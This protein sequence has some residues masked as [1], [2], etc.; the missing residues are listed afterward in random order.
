MPTKFLVSRRTMLKTTLLLAAC[1]DSEP[2][3]PQ[4]DAAA[5]DAAADGGTCPDDAGGLC[6]GDAGDPNPQSSVFSIWRQMQVAVRSSPDHLAFEAERVV[7]TRD[8]EKI[9]RFVR[10]NIT[11]MPASSDDLGG[12]QRALWGSS[13]TLRGGMGTLRDKAELLAMLLTRAGFEATLLEGRAADGPGAVARILRDAKRVAPPAFA[14]SLRAAELARWRSALGASDALSPTLI[15]P[16]SE[17][18]CRALATRV[19]AALP[20]DTVATRTIAWAPSVAPSLPLVGV[21]IA[22]A[23]K[24][25]NTAYA[26]LAFG[27][28]GVSEVVP[29]RE[30]VAPGKARFTLSMVTT[31]S[32]PT[33]IDLVSLELDAEQLLGRSLHASFVPALPI[34]AFAHTPLADVR[35]FTP[36]LCVRGPQLA[37]AEAKQL[38][39]AGAALTLEAE[40]LEIASAD[41]A[42]LGGRPL[43][44]ASP[45]ASRLA[46]VVK[47]EAAVDASRFPVVE[48]RVSALDNTSNSVSG[49]NARAFS[50]S[51]D[52][53]P[54]SGMLVDNQPAPA[55]VLFILDKSDSIPP[56]FRDQALADLIRGIATRLR[57]QV[58]TS[59]FRVSVVGGERGSGSWR[60]E[61]AAVAQDAIDMPGYGS[62]LWPWLSEASK[63]G[64]TVFVFI[65]DGAAEYDAA[66]H[67]LAGLTD[68]PPGILVAAGMLT[69]RARATLKQMA[70]ATGSEVL[71]PDGSS[72]ADALTQRLLQQT[73]SDYRLRYRAPSSERT[74]REVRVTLAGSAPPIS[75]SVS[76]DVPTADERRKARR[77]VGLLLSA[78]LPHEE[79]VTRVLVGL[80]EPISDMPSTLFDEVEAALFGSTEIRFEGAPPTVAV[81]LDESL[82]YK[83]QLEPLTLARQARDAAKTIAAYLGRPVPR[84]PI[85]R[86]LLERVDSA[87]DVPTFPSGLRAAGFSASLR[88]D[89][90][91]RFVSDIWPVGAHHTPSPSARESFVA[92]LTATAALSLWERAIFKRS[93][94]GSLDDRPLTVLST[95][96]AET[97]FPAAAAGDIARWKLLAQYNP[98]WM[99][100][101]SDGTP[102]AAYLV[103]RATGAV[104]AIGS[105]GAGE[106]LSDCAEELLDV[107]DFLASL[108]S[109]TGVIGTA[110]GVWLSLELTLLHKLVAATTVIA[111]GMPT[112]DPTD[113]SDL[114][115]PIQ[116][117]ALGEFLE[118]ITERESR[119]LYPLGVY[120]QGLVMVR[121]LMDLIESSQLPTSC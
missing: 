116:D 110:G 16:P 21:R 63:T 88:P 48:L 49:L 89:G 12:S 47:L 85:A 39:A 86:C 58:P 80:R 46:S 5:D 17:S 26:D 76:Y 60:R 98:G 22:R 72:I 83:L 91:V 59:E 11:T 78:H 32:G 70:H 94:A 121:D 10:D 65:T 112:E 36:T 118:R 66:P 18:E 105:A 67:D 103:D 114:A 101:P 106:G 3:T 23:M 79:P 108:A 56:E 7:K 52:G 34:G 96:Y 104:R 43:H 35:V 27:D 54:V 69:D 15:S 19:L 41:Q 24:Y 68:M 90:S 31:T 29:A 115:A 107:A 20:A 8:P 74:R 119:F 93:A 84:S 25:C 102:L 100:T 53:A 81:Q 14:P 73:R 13:G 87:G 45:S 38:S 33:P 57:E 37:A 95:I 9:F 120:A 82:E 6:A 42:M 55:R 71:M 117:G 28:S 77:L 75:V 62:D 109:F 92:T 51:E 50:L 99:V 113:F 4:L 30:R 61:P 97:V 1:R 40:R 2:S 111:G 64:P 44:L